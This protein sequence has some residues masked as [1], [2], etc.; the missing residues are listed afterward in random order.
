VLGWNFTTDEIELLNDSKKI[1]SQSIFQLG[2]GNSF[3]TDKRLIDGLSGVILLYVKSWEP[4]TMD[5]MDTLEL[6]VENR[7]I[8]RVEIL[9]V[10]MAKEFYKNSEDD[11]DVWRRKVETI[12]SE[13][14]W[15]IDYAT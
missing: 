2:G 12:K 10:G 14:V 5:F 15:I 3:N 9:P 6:L 11:L 13:K 1:S 7:Y 8:E 4:P